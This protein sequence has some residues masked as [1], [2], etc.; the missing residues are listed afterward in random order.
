MLHK[1]MKLVQ[2]PALNDCWA[3]LE[4][5][6]WS[7]ILCFKQSTYYTFARYFMSNGFWW[8]SCFSRVL[9]ITELFN[10]TY[11]DLYSP[12]IWMVSV[13]Y[14]PQPY[15]FCWNE[16]PSSASGSQGWPCCSRIPIAGRLWRFSSG[17]RVRIY[18]PAA[19]RVVLADAG[20]DWVPLKEPGKSCNFSECC[21]EQT[22][23]TKLFLNVKVCTSIFFLW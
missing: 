22:L 6:A 13:N 18:L 9:W 19:S 15:H 11:G 1:G 17:V 23:G 20:A 7:L 16:V 3:S 12:L 2:S 14:H 5:W 4:G 21:P 8:S 10:Q